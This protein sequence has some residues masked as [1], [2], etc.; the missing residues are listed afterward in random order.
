MSN[1]SVT[2]FGDPHKH[3]T[4]LTIPH[5]WVTIGRTLLAVCRIYIVKW[6]H[7]SE[8]QKWYAYS[9]PIR[10]TTWTYSSLRLVSVKQKPRAD[11]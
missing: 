10:S 11:F 4:H 3:K 8:N 2:F 6:K 1:I 7:F 5:K 9:L